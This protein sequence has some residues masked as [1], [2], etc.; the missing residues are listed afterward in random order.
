MSSSQSGSPQDRTPGL[1]LFC[2]KGW[3]V[4]LGGWLVLSCRGKTSLPG[5]CSVGQSGESV[6]VWNLISFN[7]YSLSQLDYSLI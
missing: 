3:V 4:N 1:F 7:N 5:G 2:Q 6:V